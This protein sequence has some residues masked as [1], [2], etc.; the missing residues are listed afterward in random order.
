MI[1]VVCVLYV[2]M[3][4]DKKSD[5]VCIQPTTIRIREP[6]YPQQNLSLS[7]NVT[8]RH[9]W[10][11]TADHEVKVALTTKTFINWTESPVKK[12]IELKNVP[13]L[14]ANPRLF[15]IAEFKLK[16]K[17][18]S[19]FLSK[20]L[21]QPYLHS[22]SYYVLRRYF[23]GSAYSFES[24]FKNVSIQQNYDVYSDVMIFLHIQKTGGMHLNDRFMRELA[25]PFKCKCGF[26]ESTC[27][28]LNPKGN[29]WI[30][31]SKFSGWPCGLHADWT[32]L[33]RCIPDQID[34]ME[35]KWRYR[36]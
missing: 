9:D 35:Q 14:G 28:C 6:E 1:F 8:D 3:I 2:Q 4:I 19:Q 31:S 5:N 34:E 10:N 33:H 29:V 20:I 16:A 12:K 7:Q 30:Y 24:E 32:Q 11:K 18:D 17:T 27:S 15:T 21:S 36:R 26:K 25:Y 13:N 22:K 23:T